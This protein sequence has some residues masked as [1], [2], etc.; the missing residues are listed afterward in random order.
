[1]ISKKIHIFIRLCTINLA[2]LN[3]NYIINYI[4][5]VIGYSF[6][7]FNHYEN[8]SKTN[9]ED[10][11]IIVKRDPRFWSRDDIIEFDPENDNKL[12]LKVHIYLEIK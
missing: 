10:A 1:M 9:S 6:D 11:K 12:V 2:Y 4:P 5:R 3:I 7:G 8:Y